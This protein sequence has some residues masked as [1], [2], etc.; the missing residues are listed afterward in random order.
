MTIGNENGRCTSYTLYKQQMSLSKSERDLGVIMQ[1]NLKWKE[2]IGKCVRKANQILVLISRAYV[3]RASRIQY[4][5][6]N[7]VRSLLEYA[8]Q[9]WRPFTQKDIDIIERV[10][11]RAT[12]MIKG[13]R[14]DS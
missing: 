4:H 3:T 11:R 5:S 14:S 10:Q 2:H 6:I 12:R 8:V 9:V 13:S 1:S 7:L